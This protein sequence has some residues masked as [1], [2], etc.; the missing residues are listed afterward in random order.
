MLCAAAA[1]TRYSSYCSNLS[2]TYLI[3]PTKQQEAEYNALLAAQEAAVAAL[4]PDAPLSAAME[5]AVKTLND[6]GQ[7]HL[8]ERLTRS[9]GSGTGLEFRE[10]SHV[11]NSKNEIVARPGM[12]SGRILLP[13]RQCKKRCCHVYSKA[14]LCFIKL[15]S[16][17]F[18]I[19]LACLFWCCL[20]DI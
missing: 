11:L 15:M 20:P 16:Y 1:G 18:L 12:V 19:C 17:V 5:A 14:E 6:K 4:V 9:A 13:S 10:A 8:V 3:D 2:R 7:G